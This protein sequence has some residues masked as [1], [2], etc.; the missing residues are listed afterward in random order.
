MADAE[1]RAR[2]TADDQASKTLDEIA[3]AADKLDNTDAVVGVGAE[4]EATPVLEGATEAVETLDGADA[5]VGVDADDEASDTLTDVEGAVDDLD[6]A[7]AE[8][9]AEADD[10]ASD[11]LADVQGAVDQLDRESAEVTVTVD[12]QASGSLDD[13]AEGLGGVEGAMGRLPGLAGQLSG[14]IGSLGGG[15]SAATAGVAA[16]VT[17][18]GASIASSI[19]DFQE[20]GVAVGEFVTKTGASFEDASRLIEVAGDLEVPVA[21]LE[22]AIAKMNVAA[23]KTPAAF[24]AIGASIAKNSDGTIN[25]TETYLN[26]VRALQGIEDTSQRTRAATAIFGGGWL[27]MAGMVGTSADELRERIAGVDDAMVFDESK[28]AKAEGLRDAFDAIGD[29]VT[30]LKLKVAEDLAPAIADLGPKIGDAV[31]ALGPLITN[32]GGGLADA[33]KVVTP[34]VKLFGDSF[35]AWEGIKLPFTDGDLSIMTGGFAALSQGVDRLTE[36]FGTTAELTSHVADNFGVLTT[37]VDATAKATEDSKASFADAATAL[38]EWAASTAHAVT[39]MQAYADATAGMDWGAATLDGAVTAMSEFSEQHFALTDIAAASAV[40]YDN[41]TASIEKNGAS[42]DVNT[43]QGRANQKALEG[44]AATLDTQLAAAYASSNGDM[45]VFKGKAEAITQT[46][47]GQLTPA[48]KN[49]GMSVEDLN[50]LLGLT[51]EDIETRYKLSGDEE[52]RIRIGLLQTSIDNLPL[53]VQTQV[54][55]K[56]IMGDY[57][58]ALAII[59]GYY[60]SHPVTVQVKAQYIKTSGAGY[61]LGSATQ[62]SAPTAMTTATAT[63]GVSTTSY[64]AT[65]FSVNVPAPVVN[66]AAPQMPPI[67][68]NLDGRPVKALIGST[69]AP[70]VRAAAMAIRAGR[71]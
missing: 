51:P 11:T 6:G 30:A 24:D 44:V 17:A 52:A 45:E 66:V 27:K 25:T 16:G 64:A 38:E 19:S 34:A 39:G 60:S 47:D 4:D 53:D 63:D 37:S 43:E 61:M 7:A 49:S 20:L 8:V 58:G 29:S 32:L 70:A 15:L 59:Q 36:K 5:T 26:V 21:A 2:I 41:F 10:Q 68:V 31:T 42:F 69:T 55:Q 14:A 23:D 35:A 33:L 3:A 65:P 57:Q 71:A 22:K 56:I 67:V 50:R 62:S 40:A 1:F 13:I 46:A 54:T 48:L 18:I 9:S 12:D 28:V